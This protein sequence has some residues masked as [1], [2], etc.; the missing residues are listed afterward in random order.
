MPLERLG[1]FGASTFIVRVLAGAERAA[2]QIKSDDDVGRRMIGHQLEQRGEEAVNSIRVLTLVS[3][4]I[5]R[6]QREE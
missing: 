5:I 2:R 3:H 1:R 6:W 4:K